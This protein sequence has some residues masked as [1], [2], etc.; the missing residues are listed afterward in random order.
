MLTLAKNTSVHGLRQASDLKA[1]K[2]TAWELVVQHDRSQLVKLKEHLE[3]SYSYLG[4]QITDALE[5]SYLYSL[6]S[7]FAGTEVSLDPEIIQQLLSTHSNHRDALSH[8]S[9]YLSFANQVQFSQR[10][11]L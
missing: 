7:E 9:Q 2:L 8:I 10:P 6:A 11:S 1:L 3:N 4:Q 5:K